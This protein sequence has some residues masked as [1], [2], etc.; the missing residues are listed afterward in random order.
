MQATVEQNSP[1]LNREVYKY[2]HK[3]VL[4]IPSAIEQVIHDI[5]GINVPAFVNINIVNIE[6]DLC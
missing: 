2:S 3:G 6:R 4:V 1:T 5:K